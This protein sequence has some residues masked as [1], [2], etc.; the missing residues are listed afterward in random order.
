VEGM[1]ATYSAAPEGEALALIGSSGRLEVAVNLGRACDR[2]GLEA[3]NTVGINIV[4]T[5]RKRG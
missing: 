5:K 3:E 2:T 1:R 4:V